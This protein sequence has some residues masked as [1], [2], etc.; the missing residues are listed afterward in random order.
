MGH[1]H[2]HL[3]ALICGRRCSLLA[4]QFFVLAKHRKFDRTVTG[5]LIALLRAAGARSN[6]AT[7]C[8]CAVARCPAR[9]RHLARPGTRAHPAAGPRAA[10]A[11]CRA[12]LVTS[13][14]Y[15]DDLGLY[16]CA[17][18]EMRTGVCGIR[19]AAAAE[20][21]EVDRC[22]HLD[23]CCVCECTEKSTRVAPSP[24]CGS[25]LFS[26]VWSVFCPSATW[27]MRVPYSF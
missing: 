24:V 20:R 2:R 22:G 5:R 26:C 12:F 16:S 14:E 19:C 3:A 10:C 13:F 11:L 15:D 27:W 21:S 8:G 1:A 23:V 18:L 7:S 6:R 4:A 25:P 9:G 17:G